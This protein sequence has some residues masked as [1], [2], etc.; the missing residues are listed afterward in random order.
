MKENTWA[1]ITVGKSS[2]AYCNPML[3]A[4]LTQNLAANANI[5]TAVCANKKSNHIGMFKNLWM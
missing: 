5:S 3:K 2:A 4:K 1:R